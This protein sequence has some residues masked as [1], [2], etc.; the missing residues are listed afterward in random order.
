[1]QIQT[2]KQIQIQIKLQCCQTYRLQAFGQYCCKVGTNVGMMVDDGQRIW[3]NHDVEPVSTGG[4][5]YIGDEYCIGQHQQKR[6]Q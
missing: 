1:M 5:W 6:T 3:E 2:Q 4:D